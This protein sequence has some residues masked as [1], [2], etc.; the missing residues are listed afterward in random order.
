[1]SQ[2]TAPW[3]QCPGRSLLTAG[4]PLCQESRGALSSPQL[5]T[6]PAE[7]E[8]KGARKGQVGLGLALSNDVLDA[9][10]QEHILVLQGRKEGTVRFLTE[11]TR[12]QINLAVCFKKS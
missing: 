6:G 11:T 10:V 1:M 4:L 3:G 9:A 7:G 5:C 8:Q 2:L 12:S